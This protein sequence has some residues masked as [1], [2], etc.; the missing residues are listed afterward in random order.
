MSRI[1]TSST[2]MPI[3]TIL[4]KEAN[5]NHGQ[6]I[7]PELTLSLIVFPPQIIISDP[8]GVVQ[9]IKTSSHRILIVIF[10]LFLHV[11]LILCRKLI[12]Q[13]KNIFLPFKIIKV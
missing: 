12:F 6:Y 4:I 5:H 3:R 2:S 10:M 9:L 11:N 7:P 13:L 1:L 8:E